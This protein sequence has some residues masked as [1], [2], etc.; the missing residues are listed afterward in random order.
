MEGRIAV[1]GHAVREPGTR[2]V[3]GVDRIMV[4]G[5]EIPGPSPRIYLMLNKPFGYVSSLN[6]PAGRPLVVDLVKDVGL[7]VYPVG[8][9]DFDSLGLLF[10]TNDGDWAHRL[11]H[12]RYHVPRTYKLTV[13]G[14]IDDRAL[15]GL[16]EGVHL[17]DGFSGPSKATLLKRGPDKSVI[18]MTITRGRTR[19]VRR[20]TEALGYRV[21]HL[22]RIGFGVLELGDLKIGA[23]RHLETQEV[24]AMKKM[25]KMR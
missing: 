6:D 20:M 23:Y 11:S 16:R 21:I 15:E 10:L 8:R 25:V 5:Q 22:L 24:E 9:L 13:A 17:E 14:A 12:P 3:W 7:R 1:N 18:R 4:D 2:A 19:I